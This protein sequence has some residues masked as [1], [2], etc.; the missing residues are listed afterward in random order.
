MAE[1]EPDLVQS[2][3]KT[4][5]GQHRGRGNREIFRNTGMEEL[6]TPSDGVEAEP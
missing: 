6:V 2:E 1:Y 4:V 3:M 5:E